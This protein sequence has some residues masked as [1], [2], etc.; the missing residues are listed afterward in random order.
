MMPQDEFGYE[1]ID[2]NEKV[3][4]SPVFLVDPRFTNE[5]KEEERVVFEGHDLG[6]YKEPLVGS[7]WPIIKTQVQ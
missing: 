6:G 5:K 1:P 7:T 4:L 3:F 2:P